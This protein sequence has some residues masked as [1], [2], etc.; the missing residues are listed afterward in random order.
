MN[1]VSD[2][3]S[4]QE[5]TDDLIHSLVDHDKSSERIGVGLET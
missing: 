1:T 4:W 2:F 5:S 3:S